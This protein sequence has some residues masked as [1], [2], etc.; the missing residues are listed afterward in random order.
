MLRKG[1]IRRMRINCQSLMNQYPLL[2]NSAI[3]FIHVKK[4]V[5]CIVIF[6]KIAVLQYKIRPPPHRVFCPARLQPAIDGILL[7]I[8]SIRR[9]PRT[10]FQ[11]RRI[12][13][14]HFL[15]QYQTVI[16]PVKPGE[17]FPFPCRQDNFGF[18]KILS[19]RT[20]RP[21]RCIPPLA[22]DFSGTHKR[23]VARA[24]GFRLPSL[25]V[26][27]FFGKVLVVIFAV[28]AQKMPVPEFAMQDVRM[29]P[30]FP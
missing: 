16:Q 26:A 11:M 7:Q 12:F 28:P 17:V 10:A 22:D 14:F 23:N 2:K 8:V 5:E 3:R 19:Y 9:F 29:L 18:G 1:Q 13:R 4:P 20:Q 25:Q 27:E 30:P 15:I 24:D 6:Q 21:G